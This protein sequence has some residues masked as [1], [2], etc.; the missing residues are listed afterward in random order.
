MVLTSKVYGRIL[1][2]QKSEDTLEILERVVE[3]GIYAL[4]SYK[5]CILSGRGRLAVT[6]WVTR[7]RYIGVGELF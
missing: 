5:S 2:H 1:L 7:G 4:L 6:R 3:K